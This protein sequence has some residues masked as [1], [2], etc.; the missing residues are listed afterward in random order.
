MNIGMEFRNQLNNERRNEKYLVGAVS[1][2]VFYEI[3]VYFQ[4]TIELFPFEFFGI[5]C[6][7][8]ENGEENYRKLMETRNRYKRYLVSI[9]QGWLEDKRKELDFY[10]RECEFFE[11]QS[12][13]NSI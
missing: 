4:F 9:Q 2:R 3:E 12:L 6:F 11:Q 8:E 5:S 1:E 13:D 10:E 7:E